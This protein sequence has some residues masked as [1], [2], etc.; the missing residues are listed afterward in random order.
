LQEADGRDFGG[1]AAWRLRA[2]FNALT[3]HC[4]EFLL[5]LFFGSNA[6]ERSTLRLVRQRGLHH[7]QQGHRLQRPKGNDLPE[8]GEPT[9][10]RVRVLD[11]TGDP[12]GSW[13]I[14]GDD[15]GIAVRV[16]RLRIN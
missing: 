7:P 14:S 1:I 4:F 11:D 15:A 2:P 5:I 9:R 6:C 12:G 8:K 3:W 13:F 16:K 10:R